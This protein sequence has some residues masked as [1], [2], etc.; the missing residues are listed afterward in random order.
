LP[1]VQAFTPTVDQPPLTDG[2]NGAAVQAGGQRI[3]F[4]NGNFL[5][6]PHVTVSVAS[7]AGGGTGS[8]TAVAVDANG[9][10]AHVFNASGTDV[11]GS[12]NW[13]ASD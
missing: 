10:T 11:G 9:F 3:N 2:A 13:A 6:P 5:N 1:V 12:V 8:V 4:T 7:V